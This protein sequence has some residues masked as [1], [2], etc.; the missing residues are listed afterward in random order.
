MKRL[1]LAFLAVFGVVMG[2]AIAQQWPNLP[3]LGGASY[4]SSYVNSVC[5]NTVPAGPTQTG[6]ETVPADTNAS[7]GQT[8]QTVKMPLTALS[9][10]ASYYYQLVAPGTASQTYTFTGGVSTL[11]LDVAT[12]SITAASITAPANPV[13]GQTV[14]ISS[15]AT[16][17]TFAF[18]AN[19]GQTLAATTPTVLTASTTV[20]QGYKWIYRATDLKWYRIQ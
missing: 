5:V 10:F 6:N 3:I 15:K 12:G 19:T 16:V 1:A 4:C 18:V 17:T 11:I 9:G 2:S 13:D 14:A 8:P 7:G 20:P